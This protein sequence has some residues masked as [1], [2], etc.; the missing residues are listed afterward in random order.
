MLDG[1]WLTITLADLFTLDPHPTNEYNCTNVANIEPHLKK[2]IMIRFAF[3]LIAI[4]SLA[5]PSRAAIIW[6]YT[7]TSTDN[8]HTITGQ[9]TTNGTPGDEL[10]DGM[11][12][13]VKSVD[14]VHRNGNLITDW[15]FGHAPPFDGG[16]TIQTQ[17]TTGAAIPVESIF[18]S[19][20]LP[21]SGNEN[22]RN[23]IYF[24]IPDRYL[25]YAHGRHEFSFYNY[26]YLFMPRSTTLQAVPEP[27]S[28]GL[29][30]LIGGMLSYRRRR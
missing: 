1:L 25:A 23:R 16:G 3:S 27:N 12:F 13:N 5:G 2:T 4:L 10:V 7:L 14:S 28:V 17:G 26:H 20:P 8:F 19:G 21:A 18:A 9:L 29:L 30:G 22:F 15:M 11:T 24:G 6:N